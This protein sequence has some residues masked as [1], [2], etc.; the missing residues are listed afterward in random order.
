MTD[1]VMHTKSVPKK[2]RYDFQKCREDRLYSDSLSDCLLRWCMSRQV[3]LY[4][5]PNIGS[6]IHMVV[7]KFYERTTGTKGLRL[8]IRVRT[9]RHLIYW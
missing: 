8:E 1:N 3:D 2:N 6:L 4:S 7:Y 5:C 9:V